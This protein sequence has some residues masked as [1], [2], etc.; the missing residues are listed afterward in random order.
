M[1][2]LGLCE[3]KSGGSCITQARIDYPPKTTLTPSVRL[4]LYAVDHSYSQMYIAIPGC[5]ISIRCGTRPLTPPVLSGRYLLIRY[6]CLHTSQLWQ[7]PRQGDH[8]PSGHRG[9]CPCWIVC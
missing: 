3:L 4:G 2:T 6:S 1:V 8:R 7:R 5:N 9:D